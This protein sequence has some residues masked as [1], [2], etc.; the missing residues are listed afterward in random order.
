MR[1]NI[2]FKLYLPIFLMSMVVSI[3]VYNL[4]NVSDL[5]DQELKKANAKELKLEKDVKFI[6]DTL[7]DMKAD[8]AQSILDKNF[9]RI[10]QKKLKRS[11]ENINKTLDRLKGSLFFKTK[12]KKEILHNLQARIKGYFY[13]LR[14]LPDDFKESYEDG[15]YSLI[16]LMAISKKLNEEL[17]KLKSI[18]KDAI[19][20][21][22]FE[23]IR[24]KVELYASMLGIFIVSLFI[25]THFFD[26]RILNSIEKLKSLNTSLLMF[27]K[28]ESQ[29]IKK[30]E[31][32]NIPNDEIG[33]AIKSIAYTIDHIANIIKE[34][35]TL[36][37]EIEDTQ[38]EII[39][40]MG[41]IGESRSKE[42]GNHVKRVAEYSYLLAK[43][44]GLSEDEATLIKEASPMHDIGKVAIP[45]NILKKP[46]RLTP[47]EY[48]I[49][50]THAKL[51]YEMLK[52]SKR[53]IIKAASIIAYE[54]HEQYN[55]KGYPRGLKGEQIHI[56]G[57][58][59][60]VADV[61][62]ALGSD[63][64]YKKAWNDEDIINYFIKETGEHFH[65]VLANLFL[66]NYEE[67]IK[68][69]EKFKDD[70]TMEVTNG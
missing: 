24:S 10:N 3:A 43:L 25:T 44:Y 47:K 54:H 36:K 22:F 69:R 41:A 5:V 8:I 39:F 13:I 30:V 53:P 48:E 23:I 1:V 34:D 49:M 52:H 37:Q 68:I 56:Y 4:T 26:K 45:D 51:G 19:N 28:G 40:T 57:A 59:T 7:I 17:M 9:D 31:T 61:F 63:R 64:C 21:K 11:Y 62:D 70:F 20:N 6:K 18:S 66:A 12:E 55:G 50:K 33:D 60:A 15:A 32:K 14:S 38:R 27:V 35:R 46:A 42:T 65:P 67:F 16:S 2:A 29:N 58:I